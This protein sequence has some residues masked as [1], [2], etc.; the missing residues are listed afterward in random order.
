MRM[1]EIGVFT[2]ELSSQ[3]LEDFPSL[4][5]LLVDP[6]HLRVEGLGLRPGRSGDCEF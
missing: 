2:A 5:M 4:H 6:Y 1:A 3:L